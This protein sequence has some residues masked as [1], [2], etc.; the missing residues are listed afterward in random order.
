[1]SPFTVAYF[2]CLSSG[3]RYFLDFVNPGSGCLETTP[4]SVTSSPKSHFSCLLLSRDM[5]DNAEHGL[6]TSNSKHLITLTNKKSSRKVR[7]IY[8]ISGTLRSKMALLF[9]NSL[10]FSRYDRVYIFN[11]LFSI[12]FKLGS[13]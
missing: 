8:G 7:T 10:Q 11:I 6:R 2:Y 9:A 5:H 1:M 12:L 13:M 3:G 4:Y